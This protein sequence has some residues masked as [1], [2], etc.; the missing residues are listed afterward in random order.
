MDNT[1]DIPNEEQTGR[2]QQPAVSE[3]LLREAMF[4]LSVKQPESC[5]RWV[6]GKGDCGLEGCEFCRFQAC[7]EALESNV[8]TQ[9][10]EGVGDWP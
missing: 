4:L 6:H 8:T 3:S 9:Q 10:T 5:P 7:I 1:N 2:L